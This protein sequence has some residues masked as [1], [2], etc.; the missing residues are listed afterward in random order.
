MLCR[1]NGGIAVNDFINIIKSRR[2]I[3]SYLPEQIKEE[4]LQA[5][6][7]AGSWAPSAHNTQPW[8]FTVIQNKELIDYISNY[9][10]KVMSESPIE[11]IAKFG[12]SRQSIFYNAPTVVIVSGQKLE[13][14]N[15]VVDCSAAIQNMLLAAESLGIGSCWIGL[16][17]FFFANKDEV[18]KLNLPEGYEPFYAVCLGYKSHKNVWGPERRKDIITYIR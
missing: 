1:K 8:H 3:R 14:F 2:S 5:I 7:E 6:L 9:S 13:M 15:P 18:R 11:W 10:K 17:M 16:S 12:R 4:E